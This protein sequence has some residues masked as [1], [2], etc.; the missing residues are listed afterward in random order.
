MKTPF[1]AEQ[2]FDTILSYNRAI[3]P[4]QFVFYLLAI[5]GIYLIFKPSVKSN[6]AISTLLSFFWLW[7]G[8]VYHLI[9]FTP[10]NNAAY[11]FGA[12]FIF[13]GILF[14]YKG[15]ITQNLTFKLRRDIFGITA[16]LLILIAL[17][18][19]PPLGLYFGHVFPNSPTFGLPCPTTIFTFGLILMTE[20]K[21]PVYLIIIPFVWSIIGFTAAFKFGM[22]ED[23]LLLISGLIT[24]TMVLIRNRKLTAFK[25]I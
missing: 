8:I 25:T 10:I 5:A 6:V 16:S 17:V 24:L 1:S 11:I 19:Y 21:I 20:R 15:A 9:Y 22:L 14:L 12:L 4:A 13:Q 3:Y 18:I 7:M 23:T 2:F